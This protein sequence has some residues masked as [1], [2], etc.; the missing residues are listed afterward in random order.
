MKTHK[1][2]KTIADLRM[3]FPKI[4]P[5][6][7]F[8]YDGRLRKNATSDAVAVRFIAWSEDGRVT[9][10]RTEFRKPGLTMAE[11]SAWLHEHAPRVI[12]HQVVAYM[13]RQFGSTWSVETIFGWHFVD[14]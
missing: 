3:Q 13:N 2:S 6:T 5:Q 9:M 12:G 14:R 11:W 1:L 8:M 4:D 10:H 7:R